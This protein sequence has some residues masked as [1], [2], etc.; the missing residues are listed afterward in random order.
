MDLS[1]IHRAALPAA[2]LKGV[3]F[4]CPAHC[5]GTGRQAA[6]PA[7]GR[8]GVRRTATA[9]TLADIDVLAISVRIRA[10]FVERSTGEMHF[11]PPKPKAGGRAVGT[12]KPRSTQAAATAP[13]SPRDN[14]TATPAEP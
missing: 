9:L 8:P 13:W 10:A 4:D 12:S 5:G 1:R 3:A 2:E 11:G 6:R 7:R 14:A